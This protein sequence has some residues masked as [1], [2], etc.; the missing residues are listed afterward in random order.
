M[1]LAFLK[2]QVD[3]YTLRVTTNAITGPDYKYQ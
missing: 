2:K 3:G 1:K